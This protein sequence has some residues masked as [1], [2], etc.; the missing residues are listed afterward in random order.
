MHWVVFGVQAAKVPQI[1]LVMFRRFDGVKK[2]RKCNKQMIGKTLSFR[3]GMFPG[4][5]S[6]F[7]VKK[8]YAYV[9]IQT[10]AFLSSF[11]FQ[12]L[13]CVD[14][15]QASPE[16]L[17]SRGIAKSCDVFPDGFQINEQGRVHRKILREI[18][19][20]YADTLVSCQKLN[21]L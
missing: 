14:S 19:K 11:C 5:K 17:W 21:K 4:A 16:F 13:Q 3:D 7:W 15:L 6:F 20:R 2:L 1:C 10:L 8:N 12:S 18:R 9:H